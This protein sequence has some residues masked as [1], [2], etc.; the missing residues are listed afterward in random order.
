MSLNNEQQLD[1]AWKLARFPSW[2]V[3][4]LLGTFPGQ[5][6]QSFYNALGGLPFKYI[7]S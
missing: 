2:H 3:R 1:N 4:I 5:C 7:V 6:M